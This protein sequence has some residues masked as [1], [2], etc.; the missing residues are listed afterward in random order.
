VNV[1]AGFMFGFSLLGIFCGGWCAGV[2]VA[3]GRSS[4]LWVLLALCC[5]GGAIAWTVHP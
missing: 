2:Y 5:A 3:N 4:W 1:F